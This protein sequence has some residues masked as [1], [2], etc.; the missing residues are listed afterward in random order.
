MKAPLAPKAEP[1]FRP[2]RGS[3][4]PAVQQLPQATGLPTEDLATAPNPQMWLL[5]DAGAA[6]IGV[7][8]LER[9]GAGGLLRSLA[10]AP[11]HQGRGL[12]QARETAREP[13][14]HRRRGTEGA[15]D[16]NRPALLRRP[17]LW[18]HRPGPVPGELKQSE[19]FRSLCPGSAVC[20]TK[21]LRPWRRPARA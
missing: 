8:G 12:G 18:R 1:E 6:V 20:M 2:T 7:I 9:V 3:D 15:L 10:V 5:E 19:Q 14:T 13:R 17:R 4:L 11:A 21:S 16:A